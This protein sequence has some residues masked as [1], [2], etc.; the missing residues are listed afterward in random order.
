MQMGG[1]MGM[2]MGSSMGSAPMGSMGMGGMGGGLQNGFSGASPLQ[3]LSPN[4]RARL[5][6]CALAHH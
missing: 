1:G 2:P 5:Q 6:V 4:L 3:M